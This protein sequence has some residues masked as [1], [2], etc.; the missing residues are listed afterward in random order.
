MSKEPNNLKTRIVQSLGI[1]R[2]L[3]KEVTEDIKRLQKE[4]K[5]IEIVETKEEFDS[6]DIL[7][8][9]FPTRMCVLCELS[10]EGFS[11]FKKLADKKERVVSFVTHA[12]L[13]SIKTFTK[14]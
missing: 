9:H 6:R 7:V 11:G 10:E 3:Q 4:C 2:V 1:I 14:N 8:M 12:W 13:D 5:H